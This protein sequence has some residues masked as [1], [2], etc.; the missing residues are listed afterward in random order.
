M[1]LNAE[2]YKQWRGTLRKG[3]LLEYYSPIKKD[4]LEAFQGKWMYFKTIILSEINLDIHVNIALF[5]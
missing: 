2:K 4:K 3:K 5:L 1:T